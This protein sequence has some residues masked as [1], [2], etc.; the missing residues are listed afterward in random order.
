[1]DFEADVIQR[2]DRHLAVAVYFGDMLKRNDGT[3]MVSF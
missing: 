3:L 1:M 2:P